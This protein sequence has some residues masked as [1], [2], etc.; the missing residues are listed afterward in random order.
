MGSFQ[1][2]FSENQQVNVSCPLR[3]MHILNVA[4]IVRGG[5]AL[6]PRSGDVLFLAYLPRHWRFAA[7][8]ATV[9]RPACF[10]ELEEP[11]ALS[12]YRKFRFIFMVFLEVALKTVGFL[13]VSL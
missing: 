7:A 11:I 2:A 4:P 12:L 5:F 8:T 3:E 9:S 1:L 6:L 10:V 13:W